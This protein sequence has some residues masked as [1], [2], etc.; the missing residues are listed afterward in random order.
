MSEV[1]VILHVK[2]PWWWRV[3]MAAAIFFEC[4]IGGLDPE[5]AADFLVRHT[6][7]EM[8]DVGR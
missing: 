8:K 3:Y 6:K 4:T 5:R 1:R 2:Y 7:F